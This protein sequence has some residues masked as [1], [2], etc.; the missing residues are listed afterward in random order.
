M[1]QAPATGRIARF[2]EP[3]KPFVIEEVPLPEVGPG[4]ILVR[5]SRANICGSDVHAWH[6]TFVTRGLGGQ[7]PTVLGHEM[8][9]TVAEL[10]A[11]VAT[12]SDGRPLQPGTRVV[13]PYFFCCHSCR[14]CLAGR[15][16]ACLNLRMAMLG[17]A[18]E[19]PYFVGGYADYFLLPAGAVVY[20]VPDSVPDEIAAGA[21]CALSQVMYGLE[22]VDL[23]LGE[24]VVVQG[25]G[26]LG[27][28][29][30]AVAKARGA[31]TVIAIDGVPERL[32]LAR[33]F[34]ADEVI[35]ITD[36]TEKDRVKTVRRLTDGQGADV[37][38]EVVG[39]PSAID[40]GLKLA[41]QFGRYVEIGNINLGK[42][43]EFDPS[44][45]VFSNKTMVGVSLYDPPVLSR[46]LA[47][48]EEYRDRLPFDRLAAA[49][50][51]LEDINAA[52]AAAEAKRDV[53]ASIVPSFDGKP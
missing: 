17:R 35:D 25:A 45:F 19:P 23:Q 49:C 13:F 10:G 5:V 48:L 33:E 3:G 30:V 47:F 20:T 26:A 39:H 46:A 7:L 43:F 21:N 53:R 12:D 40:E 29:A 41:A 34:G 27:L 22:R 36:T 6:G 28:Y 37:V 4:E 38:V 44:R 9:G 14:N 52:F 18:D 11:G 1:T 50:Y 16:N 2:D 15:R 42:T 51:P 32:E 31:K 8:V 24:T